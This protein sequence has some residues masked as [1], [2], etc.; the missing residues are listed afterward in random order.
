MKSRFDM[1]KIIFEAPMHTSFASLERSFNARRG[2]FIYFLKKEGQ[3]SLINK[4]LKHSKIE[5]I[6]SKTKA[7]STSKERNERKKRRPSVKRL[8]RKDI[9]CRKLTAI[10]YLI[11]GMKRSEIQKLMKI[12]APYLFEVTSDKTL[13]E[14]GL[15]QVWVEFD[16]EEKMSA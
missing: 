14:L 2:G 11:G 6:V 5:K 13:F 12:S 16:H 1:D 9:G 10:T 4:I 15:R 8:R 7:R 3:Y